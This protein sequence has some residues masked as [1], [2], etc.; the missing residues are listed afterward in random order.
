MMVELDNLHFFPR[1]LVCLYVL[2]VLVALV[3]VSV[4]VVSILAVVYISM[5]LRFRAVNPDASS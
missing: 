5:T 1:F 3:V 4:F 2:V